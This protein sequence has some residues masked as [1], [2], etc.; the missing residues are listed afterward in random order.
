MKKTPPKTILI[1]EDET[2]LS[3][4]YYTLLD[5]AGYDVKVASNGQDALDKT[6]AYEPDLILL[7]LRMP[8]MTGIDFLREYQLLN[9]HPDVKVIVFS[10]YDMQAEIDE[11][12]K[13]GADRY[14]LK[15]WASPKEIL[16]LVGSTL[17]TEKV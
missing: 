9:K 12:Y 10:N 4:A 5:Q 3:E 13:L 7:D 11:A 15:A 6:E 1:V 14:I 17:E 16:D 2:V 8:V